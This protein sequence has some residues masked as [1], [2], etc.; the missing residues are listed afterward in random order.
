MPGSAIFKCA[1]RRVRAEARRLKLLFVTGSRQLPSPTGRV[2]G[3]QLTTQR[4]QGPSAPAARPVRGILEH[5]RGG[6]GGMPRSALREGYD[7]PHDNRLG[8]SCWRGS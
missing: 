8:F 4:G 3:S 1:Y 7:L 5:F 6:F 2:D